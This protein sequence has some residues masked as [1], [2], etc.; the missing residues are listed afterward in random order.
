MTSGY[1]NML[2]SILLL[3]FLLKQALSFSSNFKLVIDPHQEECIHELFQEN[4]LVT[5]E[6]RSNINVDYSIYVTSDDDIRT[7]TKKKNLDHTFTTE[8]GGF[9]SICITNTYP[10]LEDEKDDKRRFRNRRNRKNRR[11]TN[12]DEETVEITRENNEDDEDKE[13]Y[14]YQEGIENINDKK[15]GLSRA[16]VSISIKYGVSAKDYS[17]LPTMKKL[18]PLEYLLQVIVFKT[19]ELYRLQNYN[20][21]DSVVLLNSVDEI[22]SKI[23]HFTIFVIIT[24]VIVSLFEYLH[25]KN[26]FLR[27]KVV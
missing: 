24:I 16:H 12:N 21:K 3:V 20:E 27:R 10:D 8:E 18:K 19:E 6:M 1:M 11:L 9:Y 4:L 22:L 15:D 17:S 23:D 7:E 2:K 13:E 25:L 26:Y 14:E 5:I